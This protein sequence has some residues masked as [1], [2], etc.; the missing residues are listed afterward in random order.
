[1]QKQEEKYQ[2]M[3]FFAPDVSESE[4]EVKKEWNLYF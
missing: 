4:V 1:M 2:L 3:G